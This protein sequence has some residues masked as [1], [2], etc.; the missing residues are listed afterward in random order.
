MGYEM[1]TSQW[2]ILNNRLQKVGLQE[3]GTS[4]EAQAALDKKFKNNPMA[5]TQFFVAE[6]SRYGY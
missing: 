2:I 6:K 5:K 1:K 4:K 3:Y